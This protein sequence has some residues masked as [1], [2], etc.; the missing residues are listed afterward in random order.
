MLDET[1]WIVIGTVLALLVIIVAAVVVSRRSQHQHTQLKRKYGPEYDRL[2]QQHGNVARAEQELREREKRVHA[3]HLHPLNEA[4][5]ALFSTDWEKVQTRFVDD[6]TGAVQVADDLIKSVMLARG[7]SRESVERRD[8]DLSVEHPNVVE[9][10]RAAR[11]LA[12]ESR[13][14]RANTEDLRQAVVHYRA[15]FADLLKPEP[16]TKHHRLQEARA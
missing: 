2:V 4:D 10:Y 11:A 15:L 7:Y 8:I 6:P 14:G 16:D 12:Q 5:R 3:Q 13:E 1:Q 9:H